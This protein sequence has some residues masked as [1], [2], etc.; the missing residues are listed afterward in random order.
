LFGVGEKRGARCC[1]A[2]LEATY[3]EEPELC[4]MDRGLANSI[5]RS[6][7][8]LNGNGRPQIARP[9]VH[10]HA[11]GL[12]TWGVSAGQGSDTRSLSGRWL[13]LRCQAASRA[14]AAF[15]AAR[16]AVTTV[17]RGLPAARSRAAN[18]VNVS[19][20][21]SRSHGSQT[22]TLFASVNEPPVDHRPNVI[23]GRPLHRLA[24]V[25]QLECRKAISCM[26][27]ACC[28]ETPGGRDSH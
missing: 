10:R 15:L 23:G 24:A 26:L 28:V 7:G 2:P 17:K 12:N 5:T 8:C 20:P 11:G 4:L 25:Q 1:W 27:R 14:L 9:P 3:H 21:L 6:P 16:S 22:M 18:A 13:T 19:R